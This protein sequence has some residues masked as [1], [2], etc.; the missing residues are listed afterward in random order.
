MKKEKMP[1]LVKR[2]KPPFIALAVLVLM[3]VLTRLFAQSIVFQSKILGS[4]FFILGISLIVWAASLFKKANT[5]LPPAGKPSAL[6][7]KGPFLYT[8][9]PM[10][11]GM[12]LALIGASLGIGSLLSVLGPVAFMIVIS[13]AFIPYEEKKM[14]RIFGRKYV[15]YKKQVRR[16]V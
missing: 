13:T 1:W 7:I 16:W 8:R 5:E 4:I 14:E 3:A 12:T 11:A 9:N 2:I 15:A 10:Y 6:V